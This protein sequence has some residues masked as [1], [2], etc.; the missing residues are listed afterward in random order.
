MASSP[1]SHAS[2]VHAPEGGSAAPVCPESQ[3]RQTLGFWDLV[4][5]GMVFM[6][7]IAPF[8]LFGIVHQ[9]SHGMA[10]LAYL[11]GALVM[12][13][14]ANSYG[15]FCAEMPTAGSVY[16]Y[17]TVGLNRTMGFFAGW[18]V[19]LDYIL[20]P[21]LLYVVAATALNALVPAI[22]RWGWIT[23]FVVLGTAANSMAV[24]FTALANKIMLAMM[25]LVL[26]IFFCF[27]IPALAHLPAGH[28]LSLAS[29]YDPRTFSW[30]ALSSAVLISSTNFLGFDA[31]TTMAEEVDQNRRGAIGKAGITTLV[32]MAI[33]FC[34]QSW[35]AAQFY[36]V[37]RIQ[38]AE[39]AFYDISRYAGGPF[40]FTLTSVATAFAFGIA[41][42][43][44][45]QAAISRILF[46]MGRDR[47][48]P[49][50][51]ARVHPK[52]NQP[53]VANIFVGCVS[54]AIGL[55][56]RNQ[57][58]NLSLFVNFGALS[59]FT[60]VNISVVSYFWRRKRTGRMVTHLVVPMLGAIS[61][62]AL[63]ASMRFQTLV[64]GFCWIA[65]GIAYYFILNVIL[66]R[67]TTFDI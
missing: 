43:M 4:F 47:Q 25:M 16:S 2:H 60:L 41:C 50:I 58:E 24:D 14:T 66:K 37:A 22:P 54:L 28:A 12:S 42:A 31:L 26:L 19:F 64:M 62:T 5:Y 35:V 32:I 49:A 7:P 39:T 57:I 30:A 55:F 46:A 33:L 13:L 48:L 17:T 29:L 45:A 59:A 6:L 21:G 3:L 53:Y 20:I 67:E 8:A 10:T 1:S 18:L 51:L 65:A 44:V 27:A 40:L 15:L 38:S 52:S 63:V 23:A 61:T 36:G 56:F 34:G 9:V 11:V